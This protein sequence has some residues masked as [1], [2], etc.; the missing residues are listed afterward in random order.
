MDCGYNSAMIKNPKRAFLSAS[1]G[2]ALT[3]LLCA[4]IALPGFSQAAKPAAPSGNQAQIAHG[5]YLVK[6]VSGCGDCHTPMNEKG[7][8]V[9][10]QCLEG[11]K[12]SFQ[13]LVPFPG[14]AGAS[15]KIAGLNGWSTEQAIHLL[16]TRVGPTGQPPRPPMPQYR[17]NHTDAAAVVAYLKSLK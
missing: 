4:A 1:G 17:M 15:P 2:F 3:A 8:P 11:T 14:W 7:E 5:E 6:G 16:M 12:L 13:P 9:A 10:G